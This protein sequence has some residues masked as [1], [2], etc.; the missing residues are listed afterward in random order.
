MLE[1]GG[2]SA[3][4]GGGGGGLP[5]IPVVPGQQPPALP[6]PGMLRVGA[7]LRLAAPSTY[8]LT[9]MKRTTTKIMSTTATSSTMGT[10]NAGFSVK[11]RETIADG[12]GMRG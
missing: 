8:F 4:V 6:D 1:L 9:L 2:C 10:M 11:L 3:S 5:H 12:L 7:Q